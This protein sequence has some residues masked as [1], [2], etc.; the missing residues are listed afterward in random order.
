MKI[1]N[2]PWLFI[3]NSKNHEKGTHQGRKR[4][5]LL[6]YVFYQNILSKKVKATLKI[7]ERKKIKSWDN[8]F[9]KTQSVHS[10]RENNWSKH[11]KTNSEKT[12][13][14]LKRLAVSKAKEA[15]EKFETNV[16]LKSE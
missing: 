3:K 14:F 12:I 1:R 4:K 10:K 11:T 16:I 2:I 8:Q 6:K 5:F 7:V 9:K 15:I 13:Q